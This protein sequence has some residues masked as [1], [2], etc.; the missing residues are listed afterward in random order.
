MKF[1]SQ[2]MK[3]AIKDLS[4]SGAYLELDSSVRMSRPGH[5][6]SDVWWLVIGKR[7]NG[8]LCRR[9]LN[10]K[11]AVAIINRGLCRVVEE[12]PFRVRWQLNEVK[13]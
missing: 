10:H 4:A 11:T 3:T 12:K 5:A 9:R 2:S 8:S 13:K 1:I 7:A 6:M